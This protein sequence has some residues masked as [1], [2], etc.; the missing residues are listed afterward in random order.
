MPGLLQPRH[1]AGSGG[2]PIT[3]MKIFSPTEFMNH[4]VG[5]GMRPRVGL[6]ERSQ[7]NTR[8]DINAPPAVERV[9]GTPPTLTT[10]APIS[11]PRV[12]APPMNATSATSLAGPRPTS[13]PPRR[14]LLTANDRQNIAAVHLGVGQD[15]DDGRDGAA[16][17]RR[18]EYAA[19]GG[20]WAISARVL[21]STALF[22]T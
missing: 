19:G 7:P 8:P 3:A 1:E 15:R 11:A 2:M 20:Q 9:R 21:P 18:Q 10:N 12:I 13:S 22:V 6:T 16:H 14:F 5:E 4:T 17:D